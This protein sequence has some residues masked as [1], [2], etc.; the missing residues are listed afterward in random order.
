MVATHLAVTDDAEM[1]TPVGNVWS[2]REGVETLL[3]KRIRL[4]LTLNLAGIAV[5]LIA[6]L[7]LR[8]GERPAITVFQGINLVIVAGALA[9]LRD[10]TRRTFNLVVG[11]LAY[12]VT[13]VA[14][15]AI[16]IVAGDATTPLILFVGLAL[17]TAVFV[18]WSPGWQLLSVLVIIVISIWTVSTVVESPRLFWVQNVGSVVPTLIATVAIAYA[19]QR[20]REAGLRAERERCVQEEELR[21]SNQRLAREVE[22]HCR[23]E[24]TLRF[25]LR[26]LDHRV[27]N[28][29]ATVQSV[30]DHTIRTTDTV[31]EFRDAF[32][33]RIRAMSQI[34]TALAARRWEGL[35]LRDLI[36]LVVGPYRHGAES[37]SVE[38]DGAAI[39]SDV[40]RVLGLTL[41]E[42]ATNAAK[43][44]ALSTKEGRVIV[45]SEV[46]ANDPSRLRISWTEC[47]GPS[48]RQPARRGFGT[49]LIEE[50]LPYES[51][52]SVEL[53]F[54]T[55][56][57]RCEIELPLEGSG[58]A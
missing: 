37:I 42:L 39:S 52:G 4:G 34:H 10:P 31:A 49:R 12:A 41:H 23:T 9:F 11:F 43:Y 25:A 29:L 32:S 36:E 27:K 24:E 56:G 44:G 38:C 58:S 46:A 5:V 53:W 33:G 48:V 55:D 54:P 57:L 26:E 20:E 6:E 51:R 50:A 17:V 35:A 15:G 22:Q 47:D 7:L 16:G 1:S 45:R 28:T 14:I 19:L 30:A 13:I 40:V 8:P 2:L 3:L 18:P 21:E